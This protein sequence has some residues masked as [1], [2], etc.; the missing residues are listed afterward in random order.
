MSVLIFIE[1]TGGEI[2]KSSYEAA[3]YATALAEQ[4]NIQAVG[5]LIGKYTEE[6]IKELGSHGIGR[7][8]HVNDSKLDEHLIQPYAST[9][10]QA[11]KKENA[12]TI[13]LPKSSLSDAV[14][15][16]IAVKLGAGVVTNV[17]AL[18]DITNGFRVKRAIYSGK[19]FATVELLSEVKVI[20][21]AKNAYIG[22]VK[23]NTVFTEVFSPTFSEEDF[24]VKIKETQRASGD[25]LLTEADRVVS[26]GR[27]LK[28][29]ENWHLVI[30]LAKAIGAAT[31]C[32]KPVSDLDWRPHHEHVGQT[33]VKVS[34]SLYIAIGI[35]GAI[36]HLAGV[37]ASKIIVAINKDPEAPFFKAADYGIAGDL[38][39]IVPKLI[40][41]AKAL[42]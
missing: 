21:V 27:G 36:Q 18:P 31:G 37:N 29:P 42:K 4:M 40:T 41:A 8:L 5:I 28:G 32:S 25:I 34:P 39:E 23:N 17:T 26:G 7:L 33:G 30:D 14:A 38:F 9:I 22:T 2:K 3:A 15:A 1:G 6:Q 19:A 24:K 12:N 11:A 20:T 10:A 35:S 13:L 16:A